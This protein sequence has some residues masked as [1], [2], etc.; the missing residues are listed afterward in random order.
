MYAC[1]CAGGRRGE[2]KITGLGDDPMGKITNQIGRFCREEDGPT[3]TEY[4]VML[5]VILFGVISTMGAF[6]SSVQGLYD[7]IMAEVNAV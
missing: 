7:A 1:Y 6:G 2:L 3:T 5:G 4:A